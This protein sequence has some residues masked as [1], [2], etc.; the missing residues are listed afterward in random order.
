MQS[1]SEAIEHLKR[2]RFEEGMVILQRLRESDPD[3]PD[4]LYNL[5]M[6]YTEMGLIDK[7]IST[8]EPCVEQRGNAHD[9]TAL[10]LAY[11]RNGERDKALEQFEAA[12]NDDPDDF[13]AL[14]NYAAT[15]AEMGRVDEAIERFQQ[16]AAVNPQAPDVAYGLGYAYERQGK[17]ELADEW[18]RKVVEV[19][20]PSANGS[21]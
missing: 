20:W 10:G 12:I 14:R 2:G 3:N 18:Y 11:F 21:L 6:A 1:F 15:L 19:Q 8:L 5:G 17:A 7:A 4:I 16:A 9:R 13:Y